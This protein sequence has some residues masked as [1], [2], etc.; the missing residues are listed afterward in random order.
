M[1]SGGVSVATVLH[2]GTVSDGELS[3][4]YALSGMYIRHPPSVAA[5]TAGA[6]QARFR[7]PR[8]RAVPG[9]S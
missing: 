9:F 2:F 4:E 3:A 6:D 7:D 1:I 8:A 5:L